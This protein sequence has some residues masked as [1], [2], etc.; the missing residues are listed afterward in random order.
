MILFLGRVLDRKYRARKGRIASHLPLFWIKSKKLFWLFLVSNAEIILCTVL[1]GKKFRLCFP[2]SLLVRV[3]GVKIVVVVEGEPEMV[4]MG[5]ADREEDAMAGSVGGR[6][7]GGG[8]CGGR[9]VGLWE[10]RGSDWERMDCRHFFGGGDGGEFFLDVLMSVCLRLLLTVHVNGISGHVVLRALS[11]PMPLVTP[12]GPASQTAFI[13][14]PTA[15]LPLGKVLGGSKDALS[16][17]SGTRIPIVC[18]DVDTIKDDV[19]AKLAISLLGHVLFLKNQI[20][21]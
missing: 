14:L 8:G 17:K 1:G 10:G 16:V 7:M 19:A 5:V 21:L 18:L 4:E 13:P 20:P 9:G 15:A 11:V 3:K 12:A 2:F 6:E